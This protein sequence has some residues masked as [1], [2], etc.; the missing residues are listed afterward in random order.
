MTQEEAVEFGHY[1]PKGLLIGKSAKGGYLW[2]DGDG[3]TMITAPPGAGKGVGF[4]VPNLLSYKGSTLVIDPKGENASSTAKYRRDHL[5]QDVRI[6]D[7]FGVTGFKSDSFNP[8]SHL[9][10]SNEDELIADISALS[11]ALVPQG[12]AFKDEF[13]R[14]AAVELV[15]AL[16]LFVAGHEP[17]NLNLNRI[18]E[19]LGCP[20]DEWMAMFQMMS[21]SN[22]PDLGVRRLIRGH[23]NWYLN[24]ESSHKQYHYGTLKES[25]KWLQ[26]PAIQRMVSASDFDI[27]RMKYEPMTVYVALPPNYIESYKPWM[28]A[29]LTAALHG[30]MKELTDLEWPTLF[31]LDEFPRA[32]GRLEP[33]DNALPLMRAYGARCAFVMQTLAQLKELYPDSWSQ[34]EET[35]GASIYL[36]A[37]SETAKHVSERLGQTSVT[38]RTGEVSDAAMTNKSEPKKGSIQHSTPT[39]AYGKSSQ[40]QSRPLMYPEE[41]ATLGELQSIVFLTNSPPMRISRVTVYDDPHFKP[42]LDRKSSTAAKELTAASQKSKPPI[43]KILEDCQNFKD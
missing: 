43:L 5:G 41:V 4:V 21:E 37:Q 28:R 36:S 31:M 16:I 24:I 2:Y 26:D 39:L 42:L 11:Q 32:I 6:L 25:L 23:A 34:F 13:W 30:I 7:P 19:I 20:W 35:S 9:I 3:H 27:G 1:K 22:C 33:I 12:K 38:T 18:S 17:A 15:S 40:Y 10:H 29:V 14:N 8:L